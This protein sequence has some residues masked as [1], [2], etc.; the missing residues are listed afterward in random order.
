[1]SGLIEKAIE[2]IERDNLRSKARTN[3]V[4]AK[5]QY[6][7][8]RLRKNGMI[9]RAIAE[10]FNKHHATIIHGIKTY[11]NRVDTRDKIMFLH[12]KEYKELLENLEE[13]H[14]NLRKDVLSAVTQQDLK[15]IQKRVEL[16]LYP[17]LYY[18]YKN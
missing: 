9:L 12:L 7:Y 4:V 16:N 2:L 13:E 14:Y 18:E 17:Q 5:R 1:M 3:E 6:L 15:R 11:N 8:Y 10:L